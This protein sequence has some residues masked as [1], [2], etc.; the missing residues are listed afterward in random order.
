M[1]IT[2]VRQLR[3]VAAASPVGLECAPPRLGRRFLGFGS[4]TLR[5]TLPFVSLFYAVLRIGS[6]ARSS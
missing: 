5:D 6:M 1:V 3:H 4:P 2:Q